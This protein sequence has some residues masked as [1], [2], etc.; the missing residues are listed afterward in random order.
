MLG[1]VGLTRSLKS[2]KA[3]TKKSTNRI[4]NSAKRTKRNTLSTALVSSDGCRARCCPRITTRGY[5]YARPW[6]PAAA[7]RALKSRPSH[8]QRSPTSS[9]QYVTLLTSALSPLPFSPLLSNFSSLP[10]PSLPVPSP[11]AL[12][13]EISRTAARAMDLEM[14]RSAPLLASPPPRDRFRHFLR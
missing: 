5:S 9:T 6:L 1:W 13:K 8:P 7:K 2:K 10:F 3:M 12:E 14:G 11:S 4:S